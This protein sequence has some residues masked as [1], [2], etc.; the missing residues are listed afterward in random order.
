VQKIIAQLWNVPVSLLVS[1][2][3]RSFHAPFADVPFRFA[4]DVSGE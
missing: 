1:S 3:T 2:A 4:S